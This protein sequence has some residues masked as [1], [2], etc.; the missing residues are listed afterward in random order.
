MAIRRYAE[1]LSGPILDRVDITQVLRP[2][3][4]SYLRAAGTDGEPTAAV[5]ARVGE[6]RARAAHR[7]APLGWSTNAEVPGRVVRRD[8][9]LPRGVEA[10]DRSVA[11]GLLSARGVDK[12]LRL[13]WTVADL[14]GATRPRS[15]DLQAALAM[16]RGDETQE[17]RCG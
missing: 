14:A 12:V 16:R 17:V 13:A 11:R 5:A 2:M 15:S 9:P 1:R 4:Q 7:L 3:T 10:L 8:L 6:A